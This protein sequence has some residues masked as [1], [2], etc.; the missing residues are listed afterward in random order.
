MQDAQ[1][2][3]HTRALEVA[4]E[5]KTMVQ[6]HEQICSIRQ[7]QIIARLN[8]LSTAIR[9]FC[10]AIGSGMAYIIWFLLTHGGIPQVH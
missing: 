6:S 8:G 9:T 10:A 7:G 4:V 5:A 1:T 2:Q 3:L